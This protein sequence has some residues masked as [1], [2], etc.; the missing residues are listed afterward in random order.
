[1]TDSALIIIPSDTGTRT[2]SVEEIAREVVACFPQLDVHAQRLSLTL[3]R[4]LAR[5]EPVS[6]ASIAQE[7][8]IPLDHVAATLA[9]WPGIYHGDDGRIVGYWGLALGQMPHVLQFDGRTLYAWCA[10]DTLFLPELLGRP[11]RVTSTDPVSEVILELEVT[12]DGTQ[13]RGAHDVWMS[14]LIPTAAMGKTIVSSFCHYIHF[15]ESEWSGREFVSKQNGTFLLNLH[16]AVHLARLKNLSQYPDT[17]DP[18]GV[19]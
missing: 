2:V 16:D 1:M 4:L 17:L 10:W 15:F 3:Y 19:Q 9:G 13:V 6:R 11:A 14:Y 7:A 18:W 8:N 12:P 5:G